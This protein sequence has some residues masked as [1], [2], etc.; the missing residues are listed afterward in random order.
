MKFS[1]NE[2]DSIS[3]SIFIYVNHKLLNRIFSTAHYPC[4]NKNEKDEKKNYRNLRSMV[5]VKEDKNKG[6]IS[7]KM[8]MILI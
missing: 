7:L 2:I 8:E 4:M 5:E 3:V 6:V 1:I